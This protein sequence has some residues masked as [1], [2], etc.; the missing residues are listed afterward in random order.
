MRLSWALAVLL[1]SLPGPSFSQNVEPVPRQSSAGL[2][3]FR[4]IAES[5]LFY[6]VPLSMALTKSASGKDQIGI[7]YYKSPERPQNWKAS[8]TLSFSLVPPASD[9]E[10]AKTELAKDTPNPSF[11]FPSLEFSASY[12]TWNVDSSQKIQI[13]RLQDGGATVGSTIAVTFE[14]EGTASE[15]R[16]I[17][18][19]TDRQIG[20]F[21][22]TRPKL[23]VMSVRKIELQSGALAAKFTSLKFLSAIDVEVNDP[24]GAYLRSRGSDQWGAAE[25]TAV[26]KWL[27]DLLGPPALIR[28]S[29]GN[30]GVGWNLTEPSLIAKLNA[31]PKVI[32]RAT[33]PVPELK[34]SSAILPF[35]DLCTT[36]S[37]AIVNL[38]DG[39][40]GCG[41]L[42]K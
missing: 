36:L 17:L 40:V 41:G 25:E 8:I 22:E 6:V 23:T 18:S 15:I 33:S 37:D 42:P 13:V 20:L 9:L 32:I 11:A 10:N 16:K 28:I 19:A 2:A 35:T 7:Q 21:V 38:E 4:D 34:F 5:N 1:T 30:W 39:S 12:F 24:V 3:V 29:D 31:V 26:R 14:I 27:L